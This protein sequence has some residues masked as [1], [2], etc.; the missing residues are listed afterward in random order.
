MSNQSNSKAHV[1]LWVMV[2]LKLTKLLKAAKFIKLMKPL[3]TVVTMSLS[4]IAYAFWLG[5]WFSVGFVILILIHEL[6]HVTA[7]RQRGYQ[8]SAPIFIPFIGAVV[9]APRLKDR[10]DEAYI[11]IAGPVI[12]AVAALVPFVVWFGI[13][14]KQSDAA[15]IMYAVSYVGIMLNLF[16]MIPMRPLDG[17]RVTQAIGPWFRYVGIGLLL[18]LTASF[19]EP[20]ILFI[21]ILVIPDLTMVPLTMRA[22]ASSGLLI[23]MTVLMLLGYSEQPGWVDAIDVFF[24]SVLTLVAVHAAV[25]KEDLAASDDQRPMLNP[26][27]RMRWFINYTAVSAVLSVIFVYQMWH[28]PVLTP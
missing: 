2:M 26:S 8:A 15:A 16:N 24:A 18:V 20:V 21:W 3:I 10:D 22:V 5:P 7:L 11:A 14:N 12:G 19:R 25:T 17:G 27:D 13:E 9:F 1:A 6:G 4:V 28:L 23:L